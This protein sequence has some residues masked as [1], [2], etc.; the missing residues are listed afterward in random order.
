MG[1]QKIKFELLIH[2]LKVPLAVI[3]AGIVSLLDRESKYGP[4]TEKQV[5]VLKRALRNTK[6]TRMLVNDAL[7]VGRSG[8][9]VTK[10]KRVAIS[11]LVEESLV[12]I[13]DLADENAAESIKGCP[14]LS[15]LKQTLSNQGILLNIEEN[16]WVEEIYFDESKMKQI[17]RNLLTNALKYRKKLVEIKIEKNAEVLCLTVS[18]DGQGIPE[19]YHEKIFECYFQMDSGEEHCARGHGLGLAG[20]MILVEDMGGRLYLDSDAGQG[21]TFLIKVPLT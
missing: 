3:E 16:L 14:N 20:V 15:Q 4:L 19:S 8:E 5:K 21:A 12:E 18:D 17:L 7:E 6:V 2:D 9:G 10:K 1:N 13:F 11:S